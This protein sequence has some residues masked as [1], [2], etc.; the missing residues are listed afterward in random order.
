MMVYRLSSHL[1]DEVP[2]KQKTAVLLL[3][4]DL[5]MMDRLCDTVG[6]KE[7]V[8]ERGKQ[9][10]RQFQG[11]IGHVLNNKRSDWVED[12]MKNN[13]KTKICWVF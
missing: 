11:N 5:F 8:K 13:Q 9:P 1:P 3:L 4:N 7:I 12:I 10:R 6:K 2:F